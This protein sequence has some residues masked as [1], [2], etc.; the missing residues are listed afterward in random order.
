M[1]YYIVLIRFIVSV[2]REDRMTLLMI[3]PVR[4]IITWNSRTLK[5][6]MA[7]WN[8]WQ[9]DEVNKM[10]KERKQWL[11]KIIESRKPYIIVPS[12]AGRRVADTITVIRSILSLQHF[13]CYINTMKALANELTQYIFLKSFSFFSVLIILNFDIELHFNNL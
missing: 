1:Y 4:K 9:S 2:P 13:C 10:L 12:V 6:T 11:V 3:E 7:E 8:F 5:L